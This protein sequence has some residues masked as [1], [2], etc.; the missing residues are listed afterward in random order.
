LTAAAGLKLVTSAHESG[1][2]TNVLHMK[3]KEY[4]NILAMI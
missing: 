1:I 4:L 3:I 2:S